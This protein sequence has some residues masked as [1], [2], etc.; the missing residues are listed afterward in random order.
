MEQW[1]QRCEVAEAERDAD[2]KTLAEMVVQLRAEEAQRVAAQEKARSRSRKRR[3]SSQG[4]KTEET[5]S[6]ASKPTSENGIEV[7]QTDGPAPSDD[8][9]DEE[10]MLSRANTITP[11]TPRGQGTLQ[12]HRLEAGLPYASMLGVVLIGMG[13]MAYINGWQS[14]PPRLER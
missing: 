1:K 13:L 7:S 6:P 4:S 3:A 14:P 12:D 10:T 9:T 5:S 2:R 11:F 8:T